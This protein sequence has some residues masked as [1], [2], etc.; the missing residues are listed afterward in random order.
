MANFRFSFFTI[1]IQVKYRLKRCRIVNERK[2]RLV[3]NLAKL[4][5]TTREPSDLQADEQKYL[6][7]VLKVDRKH[8]ITADRRHEQYEN[9]TITEQA[10]SKRV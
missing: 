2:N 1:N 7:D 6:S 4:N 3:V 10:R 9:P 8:P 5:N